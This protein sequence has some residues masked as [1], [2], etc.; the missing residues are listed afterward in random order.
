MRRGTDRNLAAREG[1]PDDEAQSLGF[2]IHA[3]LV[4]RP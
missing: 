1:Q 4:K 3:S 2:A